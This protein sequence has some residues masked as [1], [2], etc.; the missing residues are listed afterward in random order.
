MKVYTNRY[1]LNDIKQRRVSKNI[2][3]IELAK[4]FKMSI[5]NFRKIESHYAIP[6]I[7]E[8]IKIAKFFEV[9]MNQIFDL[10]NIKLT[11]MEI[12]KCYKKIIL[13]I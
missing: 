1:C 9:S 3:Q 7:H 5:T 6:L 8:R 11:E 13:R 4:I 2:T 10:E 12:S